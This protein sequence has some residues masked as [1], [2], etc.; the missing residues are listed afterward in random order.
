MMQGGTAGAPDTFRATLAYDEFGQRKLRYKLKNVELGLGQIG[1]VMLEWA[2]KAYPV[3]K[4]IRVVEPEWNNEEEMVR[5]QKINV[6][7]FDSYGDMVQKFNDIS[8]GKYDVII[9]GGSTMPSNRWSEQQAYKEDLQLGIIDDIEYIKKTDI[10]DRQGLIERKSLYVQQKQQIDQ[11][12]EQY[13]EL[14]N[15]AQK[16]DNQLLQERKDAE[17]MRARYEELIRQMKDEMTSEI[18]ERKTKVRM[19][20]AYNDFVNELE[21]MKIKKSDTQ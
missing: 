11:M 8:I 3:E 13:E 7:I 20:K 17:V 6:P 1:K 21:K 14:A 12:S 19:D 9:K 5:Y 2:Q 16:L 18:T 15:N 10:Y 4:T